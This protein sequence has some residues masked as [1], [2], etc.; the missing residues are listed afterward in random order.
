M[1]SAAQTFAAGAAQK[2][3]LPRVFQLSALYELGV[4]IPSGEVVMIAGRSGSFKSGFALY[5]MYKLGLPTIYFAA[6]MDPKTVAY[7]LAAMA[8]GETTREVAQR[9]ATD[10]AARDRY[11][12]ILADSPITFVYDSPI[13]W[14]GIDEVLDAYV[15]IWDRY[16]AALVFDNFMDFAGAAAEYAEQMETMQGIT[17]LCRE[18]GATTFVLHHASDKSQTRRDPWAPPTRSEVKGGLSEKPSLSLSVA[19]QPD[20]NEFRI[21]PIKFRHGK[22]DPMAERPAVLYAD[23]ERN[24]FHSARPVAGM[25]HTF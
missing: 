23:P 17:E 2:H 21:A 24:L 6:D 22:A 7:R 8:T 11:T 10:A 19:L 16:P 1:F 4:D 5:L 3:V 20:S 13:T 15:E 18:I 25:T 9:A 12:Q 14:E